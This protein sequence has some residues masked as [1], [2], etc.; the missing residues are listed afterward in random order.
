MRGVDISVKLTLYR[1]PAAYG[2]VVP[3]PPPLGT[4][5]AAIR[6][7]STVGWPGPRTRRVGLL[8]D[9]YASAAPRAGSRR[10]GTG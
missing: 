4:Y 5:G 8:A 3:S 2:G 10:E 9:G 1:L 6:S 7:A